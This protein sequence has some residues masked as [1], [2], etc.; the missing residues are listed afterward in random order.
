MEPEG[1]SPHS[2]APA[3]CLSGYIACDM[4]KSFVETCNEIEVKIDTWE[5][6]T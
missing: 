3:T 2:Q 1:S 6:N 4:I 5:H